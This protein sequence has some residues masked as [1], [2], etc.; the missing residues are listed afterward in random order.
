M[1][2]L[3]WTIDL[4]IAAIESR[5]AASRR[6]ITSVVQTW[7]PSMAH[8]SAE[9]TLRQVALRESST[10]PA[11]EDQPEEQP[12]RRQRRAVRAGGKQPGAQGGGGGAWRA[13]LH[14]RAKGRKLCL[15]VVRELSSEFRSLS[16]QEQS[17]F[18]GLGVAGNLAWRH[19]YASFGPRQ[20]QQKQP[21]IEALGTEMPDGR[22]VL[23]DASRPAELQLVA[24]RD[25][26]VDIRDI[27]SKFRKHQADRQAE[28]RRQ[29]LELQQARAE[30]V[31]RAPAAWSQLHV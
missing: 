6:I 13:F 22:L 29:Q 18:Q 26:T 3:A 14:E 16:P 28:V 20:R 10:R 25:F 7:A 31:K 4:D 12:N 15:S 21:S 11:S 1:Q 2:A 19:G 17:Y 30:V 27:R 9:W 5:H 8:V 24:C 23:P